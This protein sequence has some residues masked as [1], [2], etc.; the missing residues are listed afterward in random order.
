MDAY[1]DY[2]LSCLKSLE[3]DGLREQVREELRRKANGT[4]LW[5]ALM[6][7]ELEK[8]ES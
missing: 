7:Q 4:F 3:E 1:I 5:V 2:K 8:L 6:M